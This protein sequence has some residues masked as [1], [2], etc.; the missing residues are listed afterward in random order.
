MFAN[1]GLAFDRLSKDSAVR[2]IVLSGA[3]DRAFTSGLDVS[4]T[5]STNFKLPTLQVGINT[6]READAVGFAN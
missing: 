5:P 4:P 3:G 2:C 6:E 1:L